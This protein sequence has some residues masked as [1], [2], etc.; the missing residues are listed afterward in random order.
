M[1][2]EFNLRKPHIIFGGGTKVHLRF[3]S[4]SHCGYWNG[5]ILETDKDV[6]CIKCLKYL[7][8]NQNDR[9]R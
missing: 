8:K 4:T 3:G 6:T 7:E 5:Y 9:T 2:E 1:T